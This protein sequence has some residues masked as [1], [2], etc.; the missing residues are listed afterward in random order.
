MMNGD[1]MSTCSSRGEDCSAPQLPV[2]QLVSRR[3]RHF[4]DEEAD[5][6]RD[7]TAFYRSELAR[8][9]ARKGVP[10]VAVRKREFESRSQQERK[11]E[12]CNYPF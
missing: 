9:S 2:S 4:Q 5:H 12:K 3:A 7:R 8:L 11:P 6:D 1:S 10:E